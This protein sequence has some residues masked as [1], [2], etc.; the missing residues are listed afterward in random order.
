MT[1]VFVLIFADTFLCCIDII[2]ILINN[3]A[4]LIIIFRPNLVVAWGVSGSVASCICPEPQV[5]KQTSGSLVTAY[6]PG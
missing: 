4:L 1:P 2:L 6:M 5:Q 3:I